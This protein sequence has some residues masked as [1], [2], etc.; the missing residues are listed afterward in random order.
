[1]NMNREFAQLEVIFGGRRRSR[2]FG[3]GISAGLDRRERETKSRR[4]PVNWGRV[5]GLATV[6][7]ILGVSWTVVGIAVS[8]FFR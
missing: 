2:W 7:A 3:D 6:L 1:M 8:H 5:A 4:R